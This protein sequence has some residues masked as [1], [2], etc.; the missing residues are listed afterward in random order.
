MQGYRKIIGLDGTFFKVVTSGALLAAVVK[1]C[2]NRMFLIALV[3]AE[4]E[5]QLS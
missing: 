4:G 2:N 3:V 5:N 1:D